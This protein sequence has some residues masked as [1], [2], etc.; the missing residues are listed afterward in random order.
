MLR[1]HS[2]KS[3]PDLHRRKST[4]SVRSVQLEHIS[5][6]TAERDAR[7]AAVHAFS[8]SHDRHS[9]DMALMFPSKQPST[10]QRDDKSSTS[11]PRRNDSV[12]S[13]HNEPGLGRRQSVR[14]VGPNSALQTRASKISMR[15]LAPK[16]EQRPAATEC[17]PVQRSQSS[18]IFDIG[19][20]SVARDTQDILLPDRTS[21]RGKTLMTSESALKHDY[22]QALMPD[23]Q[24]YTPEDDVASMPS[25]FRRVRKTR[26]MF[27][28]RNAVR[29]SQIG[30]LPSPESLHQATPPGAWSR[31]PFM[32]RKENDLPPSTPTLKAPKFTSLLRYRKDRVSNSTA[33]QDP[34]YDHSPTLGSSPEPSFR[35]QIRPKPSLFFGTKGHRLTPGMRKTLRTSTSIGAL[36]VSDTT[37][38]M[39]MSVHGSMRIKARKVSSSIK[40]R[41]KNLFIN[42][43]E[44]DAKFPAQ[45]IEAQRSHVADLF[46]VHHFGP[47]AS[48]IARFHVH[49]PSSLS[50]VSAHLPALHS[51]PSNERLRS[52]SGSID[53]FRIKDKRLSDDKSRVT[54]WASTEANT[55]I[56][57]KQENSEEWDRQRLSVITEHGL[58]AL[59]PSLPRP[60]LGLQTITSQEELAP[61]SISERLAP[62]AM[63]DS[64]RVYSAL[65]KKMNDTQQ[66]LESVRKTSDGSDPFRTLSPPTS[67]DSSEGSEPAF[68]QAHPD[69]GGHAETDSTYKQLLPERNPARLSSSLEAARSFDKAAVEHRPLSPPVHLTP[70]GSEKPLTDRS[71]AFFGSPTSHLFRTRSPWRRSL[72]VAI[73]KDRNAFQEPI[74]DTSDAVAAVRADDIGDKKVDSASNYSQDTQIHKL[75]MRQEN[76]VAGLSQSMKEPWCAATLCGD[77]PM[78]YRP[79]EDRHV[80]TSSS[81]D[82]KKRLSY[83][84]ADTERSPPSPTRVSGRPYEIEY[85]VPTMPRAFGHGH[86]REP[87]QIGSYEEDENT[88]SPAVHMPTNPTTPLG[89]IEPNVIKLTPQ[90]RAVMQTTPPS[91]TGF[92][93][94]ESA[95]TRTSVALDE[96]GM[97][98]IV[99]R[100]TLRPR[101]SPLSSENSRSNS[102]Q[103]PAQEPRPPIRQAK[104]SQ[105][106]GRIL[107]E[108]TGSPRRGSPTVRL[109]RKTAEKLEGADS[110]AGSTPGFSTAFERH[111]G[112][113]PKRLGKAKENRS[114]V[115]D[116]DDMQ[117]GEIATTDG[118]QQMRGSQTTGNLFLSSRWQRRSGEGASFL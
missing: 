26:S 46:D 13:E 17:G 51:V 80:S 76:P 99:P 62:G 1:R 90:Q 65:M 38:S 54:S 88:A 69:G 82:W 55:F 61:Q 102:L 108:G 32:N 85:I 48:D 75:D 107:A 74:S 111:I 73:D 94:N 10:S 79:R 47:A 45:Q 31:I 24:Q 98:Y 43:S 100:G 93:E 41:L 96:D 109:M 95:P 19:G 7:L 22:L 84:V 81:V 71:S 113:L 33:D 5:A 117:K 21:S 53:S 23:H 18:Q 59:S 104:S 70:K 91:A 9:T 56:A 106:V 105:T 27:T 36:P 2:T 42:K 103:T 28:T 60:K 8:R 6:A 35:S 110:P 29:S 112:S 44:D 89:S 11:N 68:S 92:Q 3:K 30:P 14:F 64:Q 40:S 49:E 52:R 101:A 83:D 58:H 115:R 114:P 25:S 20:P 12:T 116:D 66:L 77:A 63:I 97:S 87:A 78:C 50:R 57:H 4:A 86:V 39:S 15:T 118:A 37:A 72:Q 67:D 34:A 16:R